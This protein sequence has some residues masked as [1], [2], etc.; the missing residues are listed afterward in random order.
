MCAELAE[1]IVAALRERPMSCAVVDGDDE[2]R[3]HLA[4]VLDDLGF[5]V[6][7]FGGSGDFEKQQRDFRFDVIILSWNVEPV[8]GGEVVESIRR[9]G[10]PYPALIVE[11][12]GG[13]S[14]SFQLALAPVGF[15]FKPFDA[16][17]LMEVLGNAVEDRGR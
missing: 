17:R 3:A 2:Y 10:E 4:R 15:L 1:K 16:G 7:S 6:S 9:L 12:D 14:V 11:C 5:E 8:P 13:E